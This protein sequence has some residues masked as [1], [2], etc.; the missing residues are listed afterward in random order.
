MNIQY[1]LDFLIAALVLLT[2]LFFHSHGRKKLLDINSLIFRRFILVGIA[3]VLF[4]I[5]CTVLIQKHDPGMNHTLSSS[6]TVFYL[7][8]ILFPYAFLCYTRSLR[9]GIGEGIRKTACFWAIPSCAMALLVITNPWHE[10]VFYFDEWGGY[11]GGPL[12]MG[13]Y[14]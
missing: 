8:Q 1:N 11:H 3:D 7:M 2:L 5:I 9:V 4:D 14:G 6:L 13:T 10:L 12:Y